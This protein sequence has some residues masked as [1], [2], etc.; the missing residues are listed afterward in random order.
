MNLF[1]LSDGAF[2]NLNHVS[3]IPSIGDIQ[4]ALKAGRSVEIRMID[5]RVEH[6]DAKDAWGI[7]CECGIVKPKASFE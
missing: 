5:S 2:I 4:K 3:G 1:T 6:I 7:L